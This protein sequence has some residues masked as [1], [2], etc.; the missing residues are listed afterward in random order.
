MKAETYHLGSNSTL[1]VVLQRLSGLKLEEASYKVV[2]SDSMS[3]SARQRGLQFRWYTDVVNSGFGS[4]DNKDD[5]HTAS[6]WKFARPILLRD[7][8]LFGA[9]WPELEKAF[10]QDKRTMKWISEHFLSTEGEGFAMHEYLSDF[11]RYW[12]DKGVALTI[13]EQALLE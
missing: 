7:D 10:M 4:W 5:L 1:Q 9:V 13:P 6:K 2:L 11:E 8:E 3:K 12:R